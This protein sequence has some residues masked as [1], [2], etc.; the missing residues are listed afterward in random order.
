MGVAAD[1]EDEEAQDTLEVAAGEVG[2]DANKYD[3][4]AE[5]ATAIEEETPDD[6]E[7]EEEE[8]SEEAEEEDLEPEKGGVYG[9]KPPNKRKLVEVKVTAVFTKKETCNVQD[10]NTNK[11]YKAVAWDKLVEAEEE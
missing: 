1:G 3:T 6:D 4:W 8:D 9:F 5:L 2:L 7:E 11:V 10:L